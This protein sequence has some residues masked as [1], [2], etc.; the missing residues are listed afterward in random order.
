[1]FEAV[2]EVPNTRFPA[3]STTENESA[4]SMLLLA[5]VSNQSVGL[6]PTPYP[7]KS[8]TTRPGGRSTKPAL[9][10]M[11]VV[12]DSV[13]GLSF[14]VKSPVQ[15]ENSQPTVG[16]RRERHDVT[17]EVLVEFWCDLHRPVR[18]CRDLERSR[19]LL[20]ETSGDG[21]I[22][23]QGDRRRIRGP[24][25]RA[26]PPGESPSRIRLR[27]HGDQRAV[28][29]LGRS[30]I[31]DDSFRIP[32]P[33]E[34]AGG[35]LAMRAARRR[36]RPSTSCRAGELHTPMVPAVSRVELESTASICQ[37]SRS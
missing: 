32:L 29:V 33:G 36:C 30:R 4:A 14:P 23:D 8:S 31:G 20:D 15:P 34:R 9:M 10:V 24:P 13:A 2:D 28:L 11:S 17:D 27:R 12:R 35:D 26:G 16:C 6:S 3:S 7:S 22:V 25:E 19:R 37:L 18:R 1:M 5:A 21:R